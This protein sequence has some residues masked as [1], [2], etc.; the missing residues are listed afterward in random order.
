MQHGT[1]K[2]LILPYVRQE[3]RLMLWHLHTNVIL[4]HRYTSCKT[5]Y[6]K[7]FGSQS[8]AQMQAKS[9]VLQWN[10]VKSPHLACALLQ[11]SSVFL[12]LMDKIQ[13]RKCWFTCKLTVSD[14][15]CLNHLNWLARFCQ[16][17]ARDMCKCQALLRRKKHLGL[18]G[19]WPQDS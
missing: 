18:A 3:Y 16:Q 13:L 19:N 8:L 12:I 6:F 10:L 2:C 9:I 5:N 11:I 1:T 14:L 17:Y 15:Q 7:T 4:H